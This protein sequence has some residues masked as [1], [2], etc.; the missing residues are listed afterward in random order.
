MAFEIPRLRTADPEP[1]VR[2]PTPEE[3]AELSKKYDPQR[4]NLERA[5]QARKEKSLAADIATNMKRW[6]ADPWAM[7]KDGVIWTLDETN[8][9]TP[10]AKFPP[11][12]WLEQITRQ[13][14]ANRLIAIP[15][16]RRMMITWLMIY[17]HLWLAMWHPG[18][19]IFF[20]SENERL[21][22]D[23][24]KKCEFILRNIPENVMLKPRVKHKESMIEFPGLDSYIL[25]VPQ[26]EDQLRSYTASAILFDEFAF[27]ERP[28]A[29]LAAAKPSITGGGRLTIVSTP[30]KECFREICF[31]MI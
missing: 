1:L 27:W 26:G 10:I 20:M 30:G 24:I 6:H 19:S 22:K 3:V 16:S 5:N 8:F 11:Y 31:D 21:S 29:T 2:P 17:L 14:E 28:M 12:P 25:S 13:W 23:L 9:K 7:I 15:K 4:E 18:K